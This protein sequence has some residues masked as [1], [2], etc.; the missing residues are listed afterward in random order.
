MDVISI[1][2]VKVMADE[3]HTSGLK[4]GGLAF[5]AGVLATLVTAY[6]VVSRKRSSVT[7][8]RPEFGGYEEEL[9]I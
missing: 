1:N 6:A 4:L 3:A 9:G 7:A 5:L 8:I 2:Q